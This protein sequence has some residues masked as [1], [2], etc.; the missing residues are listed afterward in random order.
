[1]SDPVK[2]FLQASGLEQPNFAPNSRYLGVA[3]RDWT[4]VSG[5]PVKYVSRRFIPKQEKFA[6]IREHSVAQGDRPDNLS[7]QYFSDPQL[8]WRLC[9]ANGVMHPVE[10][11]DTV[12]ESVRIT[13]PEGVPAPTEDT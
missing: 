12:G 3:T 5:Q 6:T 11:T 2:Q 8:Y 7:A 1:M 4:P 13:L 10:L 9:D